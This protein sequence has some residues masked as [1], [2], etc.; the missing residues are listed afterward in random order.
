MAAGCACGTDEEIKQHLLADLE[1]DDLSRWPPFLVYRY[2]YVRGIADALELDRDE[3]L[4]RFDEAFPDFAPVAFDDG[5]R[6]A[7]V[8]TESSSAVPYRFVQR[9]L[10]VAVCLGL[11]AGIGLSVLDRHDAAVPVRTPV[12]ERGANART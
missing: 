10:A 11:L 7:R 8:R 2:G 9:G 4:D 5:R 6:P 3:L 12:T 1:E